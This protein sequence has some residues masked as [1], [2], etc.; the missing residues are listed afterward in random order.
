[1]GALVIIADQSGPVL[2]HFFGKSDV[3]WMQ[4]DTHVATGAIL[5]FPLM[6]LTEIT[7]LKFTSSMALAGSMFIVV[8]VVQQTLAH[9]ASELEAEYG[10][11][12]YFPPTASSLMLALPSACLSYQNQ[13]QVPNIYAELRP[14]LKNVKSMAKMIF[15]SIACIILPL[16]LTTAFAGYFMFRA[17]TPADVLEGP[18]AQTET[19]IF[20]ARMLLCLNAVFRVPVNHFTARSALYTLYKRFSGVESDEPTFSGRLF[21]IEVLTFSSIMI[22]IGMMLKSLVVVLDIMSATCAMAVMFYIPGLFLFKCMNKSPYY[23]AW[24]CLACVFFCV[25]AC[26]TVVSLHNIMV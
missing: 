26:L 1:V 12:S 16:Y 2:T 22:G 7:S 3:W 19:Q 24:K 21:W 13:M 8:C 18:Y 10:D 17:Q 11:V 6:C 4:R 15:T 20:A 5:A 25:G 9:P 14:E 23:T